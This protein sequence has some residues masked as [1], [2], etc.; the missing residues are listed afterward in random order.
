MMVP[1]NSGTYSALLGTLM[2]TSAAM[3]LPRGILNSHS[4]AVVH[5]PCSAGNCH[6]LGMLGMCHEGPTTRASHGEA[7]SPTHPGERAREDQ[8]RQGRHRGPRR[9]TGFLEQNQQVQK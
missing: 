6:E 2:E 1:V 3:L 4:R 7:R 8:E 9:G 5:E